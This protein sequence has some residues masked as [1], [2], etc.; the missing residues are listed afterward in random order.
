GGGAGDADLL[1]R[2]QRVDGGEVVV[3]P[4]DLDDGQCAAATGD[5]VD[6]ADRALQAARDDAVALEPQPPGGQALA[7][8]AAAP[9]PPAIFAAAGLAV[10]S[11]GSPPPVSARA[12]R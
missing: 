10:A 7:A 5:D 2:P 6:L 4:L 8:A 11:H 3:A 1:A 12:R 9:G